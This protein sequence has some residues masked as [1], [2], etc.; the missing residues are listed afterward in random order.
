M[1]KSRHPNLPSIS[2]LL[3]NLSTSPPSPPRIIV[4]GEDHQQSDCISDKKEQDQNHLNNNNNNNNNNLLSPRY[5]TKSSSNDH[6]SVTLSP[7]LSPIDSYASSINSLSPNSS[8]TPT[9][10]QPPSPLPSPAML[11]LPTHNY[12]LHAPLQGDDP[13]RTLKRHPSISSITSSSP[14]PS[15][16]TLDSHHSSWKSNHS[17][18]GSSSS[19]PHSPTPQYQQN[20]SNPPSSPSYYS[21]SPRPSFSQQQEQQQPQQPQQQQSPS[22]HNS[23]MMMSIDENSIH[24]SRSPSPSP[25]SSTRN[26]VDERPPLPPSTQIVLSESGQPILKRRRGRPPSLRE[27][28]LEGG[29]TFLTPTVW[30]VNHSASQQQQENGNTNNNNYTQQQNNNMASSATSTTTSAAATDAIMNGSM[31]AFTS[32]NMDMVLQMP[33]K[34]RGRKPKTH[35]V[36][37]S[38]FVWKDITATRRSTK[39]IKEQQESASVA[40]ADSNASLRR[41]EPN[42]K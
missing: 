9:S 29:W 38:C 42:T 11:E 39:V 28:A 16:S 31:A 40:N 2:T 10:F 12:N 34:K 41:L 5:L 8:T 19:T 23:P 4:V 1:N 14:K 3:T 24:S 21:A 25:P 7:I 6:L 13:P 33:R 22:S 27:P 15:N 20:Y 17:Y 32:S 18:G 35:I 26:T 36:G 37:N 30:D